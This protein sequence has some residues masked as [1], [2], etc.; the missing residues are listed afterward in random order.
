MF[1]EARK[2][3]RSHATG[4]QNLNGEGEDNTTHVRWNWLTW[5]QGDREKDQ[6]KVR[7]YKVIRKPATL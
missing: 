4:E 3:E 2:I 6:P 5:G 7:M 1:A